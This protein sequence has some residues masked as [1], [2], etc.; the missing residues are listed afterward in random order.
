[1]AG[2]EFVIIT[3]GTGTIYLAYFFSTGDEGARPFQNQKEK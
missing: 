2:S 3:R 1:M